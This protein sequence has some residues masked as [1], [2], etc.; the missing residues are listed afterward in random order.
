MDDV[1]VKQVNIKKNAFALSNLN[2]QERY[3]IFTVL[4][5]IANSDGIT[6]DENIVLNDIRLELEIDST[7]YEKAKWGKSSM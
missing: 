6:D 1:K 7:E 5:L 4:L 2:V 3:A